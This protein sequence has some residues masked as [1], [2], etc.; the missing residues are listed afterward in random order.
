MIIN[1]CILLSLPDFLHISIEIHSTVT[2]FFITFTILYCRIIVS[3][4]MI[5]TRQL[6][7]RAGPQKFDQLGTY[8]VLVINQL[9][10][11]FCTA[12]V[13]NYNSDF[14]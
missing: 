7:N 3:L 11:F 6:Q 1:R 12:I 2:F 13:H 14:Q 9:L 4:T 10:L 5:I 8:R